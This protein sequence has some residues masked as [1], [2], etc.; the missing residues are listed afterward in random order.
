MISLFFF[1]T[2]SIT[3]SLLTQSTNVVYGSDVV[4]TA[5]VTSELSSNPIKW[6]KGSTKLLI[7]APKYT[8]NGVGPGPVTLTINNVNFDDT[9][10]YQVE[11]SNSAGTTSTSNQVSLTVTGGIVGHPLYCILSNWIHFAT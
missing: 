5:T 3:V 9:G 11:A 10:V 6:L 2:G 8:Q 7:A 1:Y 4:L